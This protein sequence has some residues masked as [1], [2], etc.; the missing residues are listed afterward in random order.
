M[1]HHNAFRF[2]L[3]FKVTDQCKSSIAGQPQWHKIQPSRSSQPGYT[4]VGSHSE[5]QPK[6]SAAL[7]LGSTGNM[8]CEWVL[9]SA[10]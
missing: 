2:D 7:W 1:V 3:H 8:V 10:V 6:A 9:C 4:S 5:Y